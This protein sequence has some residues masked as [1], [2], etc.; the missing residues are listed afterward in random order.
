[1][2]SA[3]EVREQIAKVTEGYKHVLEL[4]CAT[5]FENSP[6]ALMQLEAQTKLDALYWVIG[7]KRPRFKCDKSEVRR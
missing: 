7:E 2:K 5:V 3:D 4:K 1:M 6:R